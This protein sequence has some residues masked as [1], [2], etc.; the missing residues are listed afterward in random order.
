ML[1][2]TNWLLPREAGS[3][4]Y[5]HNALDIKLAQ[6]EKRLGQA[7]QQLS[8]KFRFLM[9]NLV[10]WFINFYSPCGNA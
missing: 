8:S 3:K 5:I 7:H 9:L 2:T 1:S 6:R 10:S 4:N